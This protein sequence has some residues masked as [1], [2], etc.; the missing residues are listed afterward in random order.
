MSINNFSDKPQ[1]PNET[2]KK[3]F[4]NCQ[5]TVTTQHETYY[6]QKSYTF[7]NRDLQEQTKKIVSH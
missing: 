6:H 5:E 1:K 7:I 3:L 2:C 4:S